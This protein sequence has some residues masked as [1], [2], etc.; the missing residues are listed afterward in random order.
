MSLPYAEGPWGWHLR[1][2]CGHARCKGYT[3]CR[4]IRRVTP[5]D[6]HPSLGAKMCELPHVCPT[7]RGTDIR[8]GQV[9][10]DP[11][12]GG[13]SCSPPEPSDQGP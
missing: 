1:P 4:V 11:V 13:V 2:V 6:G 10:D 8:C 9:W 12:C 3:S 7:H 5:L